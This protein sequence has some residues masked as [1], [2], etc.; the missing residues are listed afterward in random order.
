V[1]DLAPQARGL[2]QIRLDVLS[3]DASEARE[4]HVGASYRTGPPVDSGF[5]G[6]G[7]DDEAGESPFEGHIDEESPEEK[8]SPEEKLD[9]TD[10]SGP[11]RR[12]GRRRA[13]RRPDRRSYKPTPATERD[14]RRRHNYDTMFY[15]SAFSPPCGKSRAS[16]R[17]SDARFTSVASARFESRRKRPL[18]NFMRLVTRLI[19]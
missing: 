8:Q 5:D 13:E 17:S 6:D 7:L 16:F 11:P 1:R 4:P 10:D 15:P 3:E 12:A 9:A 2:L 18:E 19:V 14:R